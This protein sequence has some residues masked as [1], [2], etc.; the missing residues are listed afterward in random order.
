MNEIIY[1]KVQDM[2]LYEDFHILDYAYNFVG[3][4]L[5]GE[6]FDRQIVEAFAYGYTPNNTMKRA[7]GLLCARKELDEQPKVIGYLGPMWDGVRCVMKDGSVKY[8]FEVKDNSQVIRRYG[9]LRYETE[10]VYRS[11]SI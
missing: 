7:A 11:M 3:G 5:D 10:E 6:Q 9:V 4:Q 8:E 2:N 1:E